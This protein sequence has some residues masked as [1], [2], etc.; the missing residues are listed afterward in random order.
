MPTLHILVTVMSRL[1]Q[2]GN[3]WARW[4][5]G[6]TAAW[7]PVLAIVAILGIRPLTAVVGL[8]PVATLVFVLVAWTDPLV[9]PILA[10]THLGRTGLQWV[11]T[12]LAGELLLGVYFALVP[13]HNDPALVPVLLLTAAA[14]MFLSL[15]IR[16][17]GHDTI[18]MML[19]TIIAAITIVMVMGGTAEFSRGLH[20]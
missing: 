14:L 6:L 12:I 5:I 11:S 10:V 4:A 9:V 18:R 19:V 17:R 3:L 1:W 8:V 7:P 20:R 16:F 15:G 13:V 2:T